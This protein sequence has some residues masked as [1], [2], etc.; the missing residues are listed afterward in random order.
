MTIIIG[1]AA[2]TGATNVNARVTR[3]ATSHSQNPLKNGYVS[4][5]AI[6]RPAIAMPPIVSANALSNSEIIIFFIFFRF[7][8]GG[9][10][11]AFDM[12]FL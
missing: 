7:I 11:D 4:G 3:I 10:S 1:A 8:S 9:L 12:L 6:A 2:V 5:I